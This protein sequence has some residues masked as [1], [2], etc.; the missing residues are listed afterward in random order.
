MADALPEV[1]ER[2]KDAAAKVQKK[3]VEA[4]ADGEIVA[5]MLNGAISTSEQEEMARE[6]GLALDR[7]LQL[8]E[9]TPGNHYFRAITLD[10]LRDLKGALA[11]Y[12]KFLA[13]SQGKNPDEEFKAR[14]RVRIISKEL[15]KH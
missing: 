2:F 5:T 8:G 3:D 1:F 7:A 13:M 11:S 12:Q 4:M 15:N 10:K 9:D 14:Q 6:H